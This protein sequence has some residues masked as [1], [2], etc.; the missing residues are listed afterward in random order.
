MRVG[1]EEDA[2]PRVEIVKILACFPLARELRGIARELRVIVLLI[3]ADA[4]Y[5]QEELAMDLHE[6][7]EL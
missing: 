5:F 2:E 7:G 6:L 3:V 1:L 4:E